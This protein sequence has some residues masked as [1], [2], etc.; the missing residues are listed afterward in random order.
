V[1]TLYLCSLSLV[2]HPD[3]PSFPTRRSSDLGLNYSRAGK[4]ESAA[5]GANGRQSNPVI[6]ES[7]NGGEYTLDHGMVAIAS[8]TSC[9]NTSNPSVMIG[10][11]LIARKA[12]ELGLES[13]P[14]VKTICAP[15]S[16][17]VDGYFRRADLW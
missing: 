17:V 16:Q 1:R 9:T 6:V 12:A 11:G 3:P 2:P 7:P 13:K 10:A 8:I 4:G 5:Q 14:W 15:G